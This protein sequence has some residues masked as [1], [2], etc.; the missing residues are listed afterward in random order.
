MSGE[1]R[2]DLFCGLAV[3][4]V[5]ILVYVNSLGNGFVWDDDVV[6]VAN[7][8]LKGT[9]LSL[10]S[11]IDTGRTAE[12][13][14]YYRPLTIFTFLV[15]QRLHGLTPF[16]VRL[17]NVLLHAAN[18]CLVYRLARSRF[19]DKYAALLA[20]LLFAVHPLNAESVDFNAGGRNTMLAAFFILA[21]Y[22]VHERS[23]RQEKFSG[24]IA[25]AALFLAGLFS[26]EIAVAILP[27]IIALEIFPLRGAGP[28]LRRRAAVRLIPYAACAAL[29]LALRN[30]ALSGAGVHVEI[31]PGLGT[32]L[33]ENVY[34]IPRYLMTV[35]WPT[36]L[37]ST[38]FV[39]DDLHL[40]TLPLVGAWLCIVGMLGWLLTRGRS[41]A[42]LF[43]LS[44]LTAFWLPVSGIFPIPSAPLADRYLYVPAIG[45]WLL[46]AYH[47]V[48]LLPAHDA[49]RRYGAVAAAV[50]L[51]VLAALTAR[52]NLDWKSDVALFTRV[53]EQYPERAFGH[54]NLGCA[55]LDKEKNLDLAEREFAVA[56][57][58]DP[59]FPRLRTQM[60]YARMQ[61]GDY[62]GALRHYA[63][64]VRLNPNDAEAHY[65]SGMALEKLWRYDEA[66]VEY[67]L[68]LA[69]PGNEL[70]DAR[71]LAEE[72][73]RGLSRWLNE[74]GRK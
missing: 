22:L 43:G 31:L 73:V 48:R 6:I 9:V 15:E 44:W 59:L 41:R 24:A 60:G 14:P 30:N 16:L 36:T 26:K 46:V 69:T 34:I 2:N 13:T 7:S 71:P 65:N 25:G 38:Y 10:F 27:F 40:L 70:A 58:L 64:A 11:N 39:P 49:A 53:V 42:V 50:V 47:A 5:A 45:F 55:Y 37:A 1:K 68:F 57:A 4:L 19:Q 52:R 51:L 23:A 29:Y 32:R 72:R 17:V 33:L 62:E 67:R 54:H 74:V 56:L 28:V 12:L 21:S 63:E 35:V 66:I 18:A 8:A 61:R 20:G 3:A